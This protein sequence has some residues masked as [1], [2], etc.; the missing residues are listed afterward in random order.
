[1]YAIISGIVLVPLYLKYIPA[2]LYGAWLA[3]GN[4]LALMTVVDPGI[5]NVI[6]QRVSHA[7]GKGDIPGLFGFFVGGTFLSLLV[8]LCILG[9]GLLLSFYIGSLVNFHGR[10]GIGE[11]QGSFQIATV[12][13]ALMFISFSVAAANRGILGSVGPGMITLIGNFLSLLVTL[14]LLYGGYGLYSIACGILFRGGFILTGGCIYFATRVFREKMKI[15]FSLQYMGELL[16]LLSFMSLGKLGQGFSQNLDAFLLARFMGPESVPIFVLT[17]RGFSIGEMLLK[18]TGNAISP[19]I[20]HLCGEGNQAKMQQILFRLFQYNIWLLGLALAGF[21]A[22]NDDF[23]RI[24]VGQQFFAGSQVS[25]I[26]CALMLASVLAVLMQTLCVA[27][28]DIKRNA[29]AQFGQA[30]VTLIFLFI[31]IYYLGFLGAAMAPLIGILSVSSWYYPRSITKRGFLTRCD[32]EG[33]FHEAIRVGGIG[34]IVGFLFLKMEPSGWLAF[35]STAATIATLYGV[36]LSL[37]SSS[38]R[39]EIMGLM[40]Y[41]RSRFSRP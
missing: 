21:M 9:V 4:V 6:L 12:G 32:W 13:T 22:L 10:E 34:L 14:L 11:L 40:K 8:S 15:S 19:S 29:V 2:D 38:V 20:S 41:V 5:S 24:W 26:L 27:L 36:F 33:L 17:R 30:L 1:M 25:Y 31:G 23:V 37:F 16:G 18:R 7:Y 28:G 35:V 3:S 39:S